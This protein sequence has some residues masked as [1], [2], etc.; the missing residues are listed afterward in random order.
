MGGV[1]LK[2]RAASW[3]QRSP[4]KDE[5]LSFSRP[6]SAKGRPQVSGSATLQAAHMRRRPQFVVLAT[7]ISLSTLLL[8]GLAGHS[9]MLM[10]LP[11]PVSD[12]TIVP[13]VCQHVH[14]CDLD[15][16]QIPCSLV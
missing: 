5:R 2:T 11:T 15:T 14:A 8:L 13:M 1:Q 3:E 6:S 10:N 16:C 7:I 12:I 4:S 9:G